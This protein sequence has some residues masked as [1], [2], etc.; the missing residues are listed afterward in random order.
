[1]PDLTALTTSHLEAARADEYGRSAELLVRDGVLRQTVIALRE[2]AELAEHNAPHAA[3]IQVLVGRVRV[4]G[5]GEPVLS[6]GEL[7]TLTHQRHAVAALED[8]VFL[9]TTVTSQ[10]GEPPQGGE[11]PEHG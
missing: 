11:R 10:P 3:S 4:T 1:M 6:S 9:L 2:G 8:S 5:E 7:H